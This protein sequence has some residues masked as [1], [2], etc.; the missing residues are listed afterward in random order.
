MLGAGTLAQLVLPDG[1]ARDAL[2]AAVAVGAAVVMLRATRRA[3][4]PLRPAWALL[5]GG[6]WTW[7]LGDLVWTWL[8]Q[9]A[10]VA[11]FPSA[12]DVLY[13]ASY[14]L[15]AAG[16]LR[17]FP[18]PPGR[19]QVWLLDALM[20]GSGGL[21]LLWLLV[22]EPTLAGSG[23]G[24][25]LA[26]LVST[27][28][29]VGD[30]V[31][32]VVL[33]RSLGVLAGRSRAHLLTSLG[34]LVILA[35]DV[36]FQLGEVWTAVAP[37]ALLADPLWLVGYL[38]LAAAAGHPSAAEVTAV[39]PGS[40]LNTAHL[41]F[42]TL[43]V[44]VLPGV[45]IVEEAAGLRLHLV[46]VLSFGVVLI[47]VFMTRLGALVG[48]MNRQTTRLRHQATTDPLTG[49]AS[50]ALLAERL[51]APAAPGR[52]TAT[53]GQWQAPASATRPALL[54][55]ALVVYRDVVEHLGYALGD[56]LLRVVGGV[57]SDAAEPGTTVARLGRDVFA[58]AVDVADPPAAEHYARR[59][60]ARLAVPLRVRGM[61]LTPEC[62]IG[63]AVAAGRPADA[64]A[65]T[66]RA[67]AALSVARTRHDRIAMDRS[68][69]CDQARAVLPRAELLRSLA[70]A[71]ER[72]ELV[73]QY[74]PVVEVTSGHALGAEALVRWQHPEHGL[75][76]PDAFIPAAERTGLIRPVTLHVLDTALARCA[77]WRAG[78]GTASVGVNVSAYDLQ[79][80]RLVDDV[81]DALDRHGVPPHALSLE[82]TETMAMRDGAQSGRTLRALADLGV[83]LAVDDYGVGYGSLDY[84]RRLPFSVL[85]IDR[86]F[87]APALEDPVCAEILRS[88]VDLGH[89]LG[90]YVVA[91]GVED[92]RTLDLLRRLGCD[93]AQGFGLGRPAP[94][95]VADALLC[96]R[97]GAVVPTQVDPDAVGPPAPA[98]AAAVSPAP[99]ARR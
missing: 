77:G 3:T 8:E 45:L 64:S 16:M 6:V 7:V 34:V 46:E 92:A 47:A 2:Y 26:R 4:G 39:E 14:P 57:L 40:P 25:T 75:L 21:L 90:M 61:E 96:A 81:R 94:G 24:S 65:L 72:G 62:V 84:L 51:D 69:D 19:R 60:Q 42:L 95:D 27:T 10:H 22:L 78:G 58:V 76:A 67:D 93:A 74:Q 49:L 63:V 36:L 87:V 38:L 48:E 56:D 97:P 35:A 70:R 29:P 44:A 82:V 11:P 18:A 85:K 91:E 55:V 33:A 31:L 66:A 37:H 30:A 89:A 12:A 68:A 1:T 52:A 23:G 13:V 88:T 17:A 9:V 83:R 15:L 80:A 98:P 73:V 99:S 41:G 54:L 50:S 59:L 20:F 43:S 86:V 71:G 79:D 53:P 32:L 28:Y 5:T